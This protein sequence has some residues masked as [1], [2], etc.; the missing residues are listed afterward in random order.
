MVWM[1]LRAYTFWTTHT[2]PDTRLPWD[3]TYKFRVPFPASLGIDSGGVEPL[4]GSNSSKKV[5]HSASFI[6]AT[7][8]PLKDYDPNLAA[9]PMARAN[10]GSVEVNEKAVR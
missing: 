7:P 9:A 5:H 6:I 4:I 8:T 10:L 1:R 3:L 2:G